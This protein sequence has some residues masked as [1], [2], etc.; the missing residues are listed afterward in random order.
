L[1]ARKSFPRNKKKKE[2]GGQGE[3]KEEVM[4]EVNKH[5]PT[6]ENTY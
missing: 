4:T 6:I 1:R 2:K 3:K 5:L